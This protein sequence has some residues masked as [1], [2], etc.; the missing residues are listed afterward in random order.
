MDELGSVTVWLRHLQAG[1]RDRALNEIW[2]RY[3]VR[4]I[5]LARKKLGSRSRTTGDSEDVAAAAFFR[6]AKAVESGRFPRLEDRDDLWR[7]LFVVTVREAR[8][9]AK[10]GSR[11]R[12]GSK[13]GGES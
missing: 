13:R 12:D 9:Q 11:L 6:F 8:D 1:H 5:G 3:F 4:L 2:Q 10:R 7:V